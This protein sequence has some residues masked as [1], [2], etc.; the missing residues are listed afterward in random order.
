MK[1]NLEEPW[2]QFVIDGYALA[3]CAVLLVYLLSL[4]F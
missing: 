1:P 2:K 3:G 4:A